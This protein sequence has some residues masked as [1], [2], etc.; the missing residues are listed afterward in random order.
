MPISMPSAPP[1]APP[2]EPPWADQWPPVPPIPPAPPSEE[3]PS[4][5]P[6]RG[7]AAAIVV[8]LALVGG[9]IGVQVGGALFGSPVSTS[10]TSAKSATLPTVGS[11]TPR[12]P[13]TTTDAAAIASQVAPA[14]VDVNTILSN[15]KAAG[16]GMVL[17]PDGLVLTN[18]HVIADATD[19]RV[20]I[21][22]AG[23]IYAATVLGYDIT[24]DVALL[25]MQGA[26]ILPTIS[27][28]DSS[29]V[30]VGDR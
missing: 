18:N 29:T 1:Y 30:A 23:P 2:A 5:R 19:I 24:D 10:S 20:Q 9:A 6:R 11:T 21:N 14:V 25:Q 26:S 22:G 3:T 28:G 4:H 12:T 7:R 13:T 16:T 8:A 17:T 15:G 27:V